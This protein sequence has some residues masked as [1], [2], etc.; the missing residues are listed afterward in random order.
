MLPPALLTVEHLQQEL[1]NVRQQRD[2]ARWE[3]SNWRKR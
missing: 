1:I 2:Q 3:A